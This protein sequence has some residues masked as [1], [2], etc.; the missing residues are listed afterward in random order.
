MRP[1]DKLVW[2]HWESESSVYN[3]ATGETH[4]LSPLPTEIARILQRGPM[5]L[6]QLAAA[7]ADLCSADDSATWQ[8]KIAAILRNL[9][10]LEIVDRDRDA[11]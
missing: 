7:M 6:D 4:L 11:A 3:R 8:G 5:T 2:S 9:T 1:A 10:D